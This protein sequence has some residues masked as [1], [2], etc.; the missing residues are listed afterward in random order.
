[1]MLTSCQ[2]AEVVD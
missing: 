2:P 1:M